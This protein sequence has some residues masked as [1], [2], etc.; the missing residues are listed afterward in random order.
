MEN[1]VVVISMVVIVAVIIFVLDLGFKELN[2]LEV[3]GAKQIKNTI[4]VSTDDEDENNDS[5]QAEENEEEGTPLDV[6]N[7]L[8]TQNGVEAVWTDESSNSNE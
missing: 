4:T 1:C 7:T 2:H 3:E 6:V 5:S 8:D